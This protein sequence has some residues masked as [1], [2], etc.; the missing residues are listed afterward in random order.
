MVGG[1][2]SMGRT[3]SQNHRSRRRGVALIYV[4]VM[5]TVLIAFA[6]LG[7]DY[8]RVQLAKT[9]LQRAADAAARAAAQAMPNGSAAVY[10]AAAAVARDNLVDGSDPT[11]NAVAL[12]NADVEWGIWN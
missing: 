10:T 8:A 2:P 4:M 7:A 12:Q 1:I 5:M 3:T 11:G 9:E 6:S